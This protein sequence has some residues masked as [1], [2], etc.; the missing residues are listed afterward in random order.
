MRDD[1]RRADDVRARRRSPG[2]FGLRTFVVGMTYGP[3]S[4]TCD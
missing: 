3:I 1:V 4:V 2:S